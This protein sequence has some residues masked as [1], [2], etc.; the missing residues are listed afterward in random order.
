MNVQT[1]G[2]YTK[3]NLVEKFK[4]DNQEKHLQYLYDKVYVFDDPR[5]S[6]EEKAKLIE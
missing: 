2:I 6:E 5:V 3:N 4:S 1:R